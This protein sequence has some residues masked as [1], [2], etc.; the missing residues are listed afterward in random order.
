MHCG[1]YEK[2]IIILFQKTNIGNRP[3]IC[4]PIEIMTYMVLGIDHD[5]YGIF[6]DIQINVLILLVQTIEIMQIFLVKQQINMKSIAIVPLPLLQ[7]LIITSK[8]VSRE[9]ILVILKTPIKFF[10]ISILF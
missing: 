8:N 3:P 2:T 5:I 1:R 9:K 4:Y 10:N 7:G 6:Y